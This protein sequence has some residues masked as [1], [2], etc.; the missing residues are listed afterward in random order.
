M[1]VARPGYWEDR[2]MPDDW[3]GGYLSGPPDDQRDEL[4]R[5][6]APGWYG[7]GT[8]LAARL[9]FCRAGHAPHLG[10]RSLQRA[11]LLLD[12]RRLRKLLRI[13]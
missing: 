12:G 10:K 2:S 4:A 8:A 6:N 13:R 9:P 7:L 5:V 1:A 3:G 11:E